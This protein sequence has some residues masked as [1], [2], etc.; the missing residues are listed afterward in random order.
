MIPTE[1]ELVFEPV[2][3]EWIPIDRDG[4][5]YPENPQ[6][7]KHEAEVFVDGYNLKEPRSRLIVADESKWREL[8]VFCEAGSTIEN[9][10]FEILI[11]LEVA[12]SGEEGPIWEAN[13]DNEV[14]IC[15]GCGDWAGNGD[16]FA[17]ATVN[18][19]G[20]HPKCSRI[21]RK[22]N[23]SDILTRVLSTIEGTQAEV[24]MKL[25]E[26]VTIKYTGQPI[27]DLMKC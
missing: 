18:C 11:N 17:P 22:L 25:S 15:H 8:E 12:L 10:T 1:F 20:G 3:R 13:L 4:T 7:T 5:K 9:R 27:E 24:W 23:L 14:L 19:G 6:T 16:T 26:Y 2:R 21:P